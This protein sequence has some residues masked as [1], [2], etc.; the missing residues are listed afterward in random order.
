M[1][2]NQPMQAQNVNQYTIILG[3]EC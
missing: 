1:S 3:I 2:H